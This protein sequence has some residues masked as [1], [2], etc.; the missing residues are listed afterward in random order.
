MI[1]DGL[2]VALCLVLPLA[3]ELASAR[4]F[5]LWQA[6]REKR[7]P[8]AGQNDNTVYVLYLKS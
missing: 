1:P 2:Y 4:L 7:S 5:D 6:R 8:A 3:W